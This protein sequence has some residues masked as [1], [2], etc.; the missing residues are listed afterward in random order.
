M[1]RRLEACDMANGILSLKPVGEGEFQVRICD[2]PVGQIMRRK[3]SFGR[4]VW[5]WS[6]SGPHI[7]ETMIPAGSNAQTLDGAKLAIKRAFDFWL[8]SA[9]GQPGNIDLGNALSPAGQQ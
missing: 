5:F 3:R 9:T 7:P 4:V 6:L 8:Q 2:A 1:V